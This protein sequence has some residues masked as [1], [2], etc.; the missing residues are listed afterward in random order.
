VI[1]SENGNFYLNTN[2]AISRQFIWLLFLIF[3]VIRRLYQIR[4]N[5]RKKSPL[6]E[7][8]G[9]FNGT[10]SLRW[11]DYVKFLRFVKLLNMG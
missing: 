7:V 8:R 11:D 10:V 5:M 9:N 2:F 6:K 1:K 4:Q 3:P